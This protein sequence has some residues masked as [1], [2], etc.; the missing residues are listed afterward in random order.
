MKAPAILYDND[1]ERLLDMSKAVEAI[2]LCL[3]AKSDGRLIAPPRSSVTFEHQGALVFTVGG[4]FNVE[5]EQN[6]A[7]FRVYTTFPEL[8][9]T[10]A[11]QLVAVWNP[12]NGSLLG[13]IIGEKLGAL[14]TGAIGGVAIDCLAKVNAMVCG[15]I[16][17]GRQAEMQLLAALTVRPTLREIRVYS[18]SVE[19]RSVFAERMS[20]KTGVR[21]NAVEAARAAVE[22]AEVVICATN[23]PRPV[24]EMDWLARGCHINSVGPKQT[25]RH[26]LPLE[27]AQVAALIVTDSPEQLSGYSTHFLIV[28]NCGKQIRDLADIVTGKLSG[29]EDNDAVTLF[30][31]TGLAGTEVIIADM[32]I[33]SQ[34][35]AVEA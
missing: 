2:Q 19:G 23:S 16:G 26:E 9:G 31:S 11:N 30:C 13:V 22:G 12:S 34:Q 14:R 18:R 29:R 35:Q 27:I 24:I 1:V 5:G 20:Q 8:A 7:G 28:S 21:I 10:S 32:L 33:S 6:R 25:D 4:L 17:T 3:R 15:I